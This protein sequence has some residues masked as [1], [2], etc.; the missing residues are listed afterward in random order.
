MRRDAHSV[1]ERFI[2]DQFKIMKKHGGTPKLDEDE[3]RRLVTDAEKTFQMLAP[4]NPSSLKDI[5]KTSGA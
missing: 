5:A 3:Y 1:A 2:R 4:E